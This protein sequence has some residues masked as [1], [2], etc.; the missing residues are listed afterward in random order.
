MCWLKSTSGRGLDD[1]VFWGSLTMLPLKTLAFG[2]SI[3]TIPAKAELFLCSIL[4]SLIVFSW[5]DRK[6]LSPVGQVK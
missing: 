4:T 1:G 3:R 6:M 5:F 2:V